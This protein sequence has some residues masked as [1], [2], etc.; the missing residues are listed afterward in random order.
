[1]KMRRLETEQTSSPNVNITYFLQ[2]RGVSRSSTFQRLCGT[3]WSYKD[4]ASKPT[5]LVALWYS[6]VSWGKTQEFSNI[7]Q[8]LAP[9]AVVFAYLRTCAYN[10]FLTLL[11]PIFA[12]TLGPSAH[13]DS[14]LAHSST[15]TCLSLSSLFTVSL[16]LFLFHLHFLFLCAIKHLYFHREK[17]WIVKFCLV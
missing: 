3:L 8:E 10:M 2:T 6:V 7:P 4:G 16:S 14:H 5:E 13:Y 17:S 9:I 11:L 1:M 15:L 12:H